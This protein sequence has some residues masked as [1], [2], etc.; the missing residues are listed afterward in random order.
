M[1]PQLP[2]PLANWRMV[3]EFNISPSSEIVK[4][5]QKTKVEGM[6]WQGPR[7][8]RNLRWEGGESSR[9]PGNPSE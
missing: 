9:A 5:G 6:P 2:K 7:G 1:S 3:T 8:I 4:D